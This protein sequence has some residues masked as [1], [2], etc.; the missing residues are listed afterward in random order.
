MCVVC[1][2]GGVVCVCV[3]VCVC[4]SV[5]CALSLRASAS[6]SESVCSGMYV[7]MCE[8]MYTNIH[9]LASIYVALFTLS[10]GTT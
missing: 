10:L 8:Y 2:C 4:G 5:V 6:V 7:Y 3:S 9:S 1:A